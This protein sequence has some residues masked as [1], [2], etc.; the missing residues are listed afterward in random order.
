ML[1]QERKSISQEYY[2]PL[3]VTIRTKGMITELRS[4]FWFAVVSSVGIERDQEVQKDKL[5]SFISWLVQTKG[6]DLY[7]SKGVLAVH[8][9]PQKFV[10]H[11]VHMQF[12]GKPQDIWKES[13]KR[14]CK[15]VFIGKNLD[16]AEL[17]KKFDEC[18]VRG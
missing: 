9:M 5:D 15:M 13:E 16:R 3:N 7:R 2:A 14:Q 17:N 18:L 8:G 6:P 11:A 10:F 12:S 1:F 4:K